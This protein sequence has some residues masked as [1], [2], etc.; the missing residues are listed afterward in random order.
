MIL[1]LILLEQFF[2]DEKL[3]IANPHKRITYQTIGGSV[4][5]NETSLDVAIRKCNI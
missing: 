4:E 2:R 3:L 5:D 1:C